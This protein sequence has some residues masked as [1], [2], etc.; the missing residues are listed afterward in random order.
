STS[1]TPLPDME[2]C[3]TY[4]SELLLLHAVPGSTASLPV[5]GLSQ[6][7]R[8]AAHV[9]DTIF[10]HFKLY[11]YV[12]TP[13]VCLDLSLVYVGGPEDDQEGEAPTTCPQEEEGE[14]PGNLN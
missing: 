6:V 7:T 11:A 10:R 1:E 2:E 3:Y 5:F 13:Q 9:L 12:L 14:T 4:F 8:I